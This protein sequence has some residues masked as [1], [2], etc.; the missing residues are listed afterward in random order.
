MGQADYSMD[1]F[2]DVITSL[3]AVAA[4]IIGF[5]GLRTWKLQLKAAADTDLA[6]RI[7]IATYKVKAAIAL[8]RRPLREVS[9]PDE[10][11]RFDDSATNEAF[12]KQYQREWQ[13][14]SNE[15]AALEAN[16]VEAQAVW[17]AEFTKHLIPLRICLSELR[18]H[19]GE[20]LRSKRD[21]TYQT[22]IDRQKMFEVLYGVGGENDRF[23]GEIDNAV[24]IIDAKVRPHFVS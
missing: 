11:T 3:A 24:S 6:R 7:L 19:I 8:M 18:E 5:L 15:M 20:H 16:A 14:L 13:D 12:A 22:Y 21:P 9:V 10:S 23:G 2:K 1:I 17:D 4:V